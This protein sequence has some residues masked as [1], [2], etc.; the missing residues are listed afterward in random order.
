MNESLMNETNTN[1]A[2]AGNL[3]VLSMIETTFP[4]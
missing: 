3:S 1:I 2:C 4:M